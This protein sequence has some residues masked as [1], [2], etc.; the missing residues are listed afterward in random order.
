MKERKYKEDWINESR[1]DEKTGRETR[2]PV[3]RGSL[4]TLPPGSAKRKL[5]L[6][7]LLPW[8]G[9]LVLLVL[10]FVLDFP[11]TRVIYVF[12]PAALALFPCLYWAMGIAALCRAP[13]QMTRL[14]KE[15]SIGRI[16]RSAMGCTLFPEAALIGE[17]VFLL[18]GGEPS[19]EW[20]G[21][22]ML[23]AAASIALYAARFFRTVHG[24]L[25]E[26][27]SEES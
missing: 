17:A 21:M 9:F 2:V 16:Y 27:G 7:T 19:R 24:Q 8:A 12:L 11:G 26:K 18:S 15:N 6:R 1:I 22:F 25:S 14:Q 13:E 20:P 3:Y 5:L 10:Y 4:F 23:L